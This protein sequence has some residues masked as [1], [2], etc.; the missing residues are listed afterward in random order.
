[1]KEPRTNHY[2]KLLACVIKENKETADRMRFSFFIAH[3]HHHHH[4]HINL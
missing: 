2:D 1:V 4:H 3:H